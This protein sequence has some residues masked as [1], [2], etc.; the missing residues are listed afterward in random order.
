MSS[1][2]FLVLVQHLPEDSEF[3]AIAPKPFGRDGDW[4]E[5]VQIW[6]ETHK[7]FA[8]HRA[9]KYV[10]GPNE[11]VPQVFISPPERAAAAAE[12]EEERLAAME[13]EALLSNAIDR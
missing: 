7:E 1:R 4:P 2:E 6:A 9:S 13:L 5:S 12:M 10:G 11:Y 3:K 8:L